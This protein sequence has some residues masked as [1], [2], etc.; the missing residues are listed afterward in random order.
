MCPGYG[1]RSELARKSY[2]EEMPWLVCVGILPGV[3]AHCRAFDLRTAGHMRYGALSRSKVCCWVGWLLTVIL[4]KQRWRRVD[5]DKG[6]TQPA[7][8]P[9]KN[10]L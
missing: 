3:G 5:E 2:P 6:D 10:G 9:Y 4:R 7:P 8:L 1:A